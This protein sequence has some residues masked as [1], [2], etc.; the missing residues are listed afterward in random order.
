MQR[1]QAK[2]TT[3]TG[4]V[5]EP[6]SGEQLKSMRVNIGNELGCY[7]IAPSNKAKTSSCVS[8]Y[9][10]ESRHSFALDR[11]KEPSNRHRKCLEKKLEF[12][13]LDTRAESSLGEGSSRFR[14]L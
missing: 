13:I 3:K 1:S 6:R 4:Q 9:Y 11:S 8:V 10:H 5:R 12:A 7:R 14:R 2:A